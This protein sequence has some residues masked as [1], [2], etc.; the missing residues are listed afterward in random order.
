MVNSWPRLEHGS[1]QPNMIEVLGITRPV[2][3]TA[4]GWARGRCLERV[5]LRDVW[6]VESSQVAPWL[7]QE[8]NSE[9]LSAAIGIDLHIEAEETLS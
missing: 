7:A 8:A 9:L 4:V 6:E 1:R 3:F 5:E 2:E